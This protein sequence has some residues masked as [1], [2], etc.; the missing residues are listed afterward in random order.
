MTH[1]YFS[2]H[3]LLALVALLLFWFVA[4]SNTSYAQ[5]LDSLKSEVQ[6]EEQLEP[7]LRQKR[8]ARREASRQMLR[9]RRENAS[10][11]ERKLS[12]SESNY[13]MRAGT[14][15]SGIVFGS[16]STADVD[17][18][19]NQDLLITGSDANDNSTTTL[20]LGDGQG[21]FTE[22]SADLTGVQFS[23]SSIA[24]LNGDGNKDLLIAG[25]DESPLSGGSPLTKLYL[26][27]GQGGFT[28]ADADLAD[29]SSGSMSVADVNGDGTQ[30]LL[31]TGND[32]SGEETATMYLGNG[33]GG[34]TEAD[35]GLTGVDHGSTSIADI[36]G[37]GNKDLLIT[38]RDADFDP[39]AT[40]Y[41]GDGEGGFSEANAG[42]TDVG[43][44]S[45][46][47]GDIDK[48]G[49]KDLLIAG[50]DGENTTATLYLGNGQGGFTKA[51]AGLAGAEDGTA[52]IMDVD[53][54]G[55]PDLLITGYDAV[56]FPTPTAT[57]YLGDGQGGFTEGNVGLTG[58]GFSSASIADIGGDGDPDLVIAGSGDSFNEASG[59]LF[60]DESAR[61]YVNRT[62]QTPPNLAPRF[63]Q[64]FAVGSLSPGL[65][66]SRIIEVGDPNGDEIVS[67]QSPNNPNASVSY[68]GDGIAEVTFT[69]DRGQR[70]NAVDIS[71][72]AIDSDGA[73]G[74]FSTSVE[75]TSKVAAF[76]VGFTGTEHGSTSIAD[77][78]GDGNRDPLITGN[79]SSDILPDPTTT[80]Y[81]G[82][83]QGGFTE[84]NAELTGVAYSSTSIADVDRDG[85]KDLLIIGDAA[86]SFGEENLTTTLYLGDG[87]GG[88]TEANAGLTGVDNSSSSIADM[89]GDGNKDL[90]ITGEDANGYPTT[91]LYLGD[92]K[93]DF[94]QAGADLVGVWL[95]SASIADVDEDGNRDLLITG[96][97]GTNNNPDPTT[98]LYL[99]DGQGG[100][101]E[102][103][104]GLTGVALSSTSIADVDGDG[105]KDLL[106]TGDTVADFLDKNP[107]ATLYL[108]DGQGGFTEANAGLTDVNYSSTSIAD[109]DGD[110]NQDLL[111]A[112]SAGTLNNLY[113]K[114]ALYL[115][116]GQGNFTETSVGLAETRY[117]STSIADVDGDADPDFLVTGF[118]STSRSVSSN[119]YENLFGNLDLSA[120]TDL[121]ALSGDGQIELTWSPGNEASPAGYNVYRSTTSFSDISNATKINTSLLGDPS[122]TDSDVTGGTEYFYRVTAVDSDGNE[123]SPSNEASA[124]L[125]P[126]PF[127]DW[128]DLEDPSITLKIVSPE[129]DVSEVDLKM[130]GGSATSS[131]TEPVSSG[132]AEFPDPDPSFSP[133]PRIAKIRLLGPD[134][135]VV[136][137]LPFRYTQSDF[138]S[139]FGI[140]AVIYVHD[141][142]QLQP[143]FG[144]WS[145]EWDYYT[146][147]CPGDNGCPQARPLSMLIPPEGEVENVNSNQQEPVV[148]VH[149]VS[150]RYPAWGNDIGKVRELVGHLSNEG[151]DGWQFYYP[152]NQDITKSG[153]LL[154]KAIHRL[155][156][157]L[158]YGTDQSFD[159]VGH[160]MGGLVSRHYIQRVG[161]GSVRS[162]YSQVL[163]FN[164]GE[165]GS[166]VD[167]FLMLGTPNHGSY[168]AWG[169]T[170]AGKI[171]NILGPSVF[172]RDV[173][174]PAYRQMTPGSGFLN[175][176]NRSPTASNPYS[177]ISTL[178]LAGTRNRAEIPL[179]EIPNQDDVVVAVSSAS[180]LDLGVPLA[181][182]DFTHTGRF[183]DFAVPNLDVLNEDTDTVIT[184]FLSGYDLS[185]PGNL[186]DITGFWG[187]ESGGEADPALSYTDG[188]SANP[189][190]G[191]LTI[192]AEETSVQSLGI[193]TSCDTDGFSEVETCVRI[194]GGK[195]VKT[196][197]SE[198]RFFTHVGSYSQ[199]DGI[200]PEPT[201]LGFG[202]AA[203]LPAKAQRIATVQKYWP[204][205]LEGPLGKISLPTKYLHTTQAHLEFN[206]TQQIAVEASG[207]TPSVGTSSSSENG[208]TASSKSTATEKVQTTK[209]QFQVDTATDTLAFWLARDSTGDVSGHN[210]RL[211]AP[212]GTVID[213]STAKSDPQ[214]GYTQD[215]DVGY[216]IYRVE[217]PAAGRW[218]VRHDASVPMFV[219]APVMSTV[220]LQVNAPDSSFT[221]SETVPVTVSFSGQNTYEDKEITAQLR[222]ENPEGGTTTLGAVGLDESGPTTYEGEFS[223]SYVGSYQISVDFSAQVGGEPVRRRTS[224]TVEVT[225][226]STDTV[227]DPP[228]APTG[229]TAQLDSA[230][231]VSLNWSLEET[232]S[233]EEY[234][235]YRDT[236]PNPTRQVAVV[237]SPDQTSYTDSEIQGGQT[238]YYRVTAVGTG[239]VES[240]FTEGTSVFTYPS[241]LSLDIQRSF[242]NPSSEEGYRLVALPG[243]TDQSLET[244]LGGEAGA[245]WQA[246]WDDGSS[247]DYFQKYDE[248]ET[249]SFRPGRG[250]WV[251]KRSDWT[252]QQS[253]ETVPLGEG[254]RAS[255]SLHEGWNII[256][257]PFG[258]DVA[259]SQVGTANSDSLR[260]LWR[261]DGSFAEADTFRSATSGEAFYFLNDTGL[262][263][264]SIPYPG[265][266]GSEK[267]ESKTKAEKEESPLALTAQPEN[268]K[269]P[270]STVRIGVDEE[271]SS[272]LDRLDQPAPPGQFSPVRLRLEIPG[273][274]PTRQK[275]LMT[276]RRPPP[277]QPDGGHTFQL[278]LQAGTEGPVQVR[279]SDL[280][281][282][283][284][285]EVELL[286][287][288]T[289]Q[290]YDLKAK[291]A[292]TIE[293]VDSTALQ[294]AVGSAAYVQNQVE[295]VV[296]DKVTLTSYPNPMQEQATLEYTLPEAEEVRLTVYDVLGRRVAVLE[297]GRVRAG[298]HQVQ[299][300]GNRLSSGVYFG[301]LQAGGQTRTQKITVVR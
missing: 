141:E 214:F 131:I 271:A 21:S 19:G 270:T 210:M 80:L 252:V 89:N 161:I 56:S 207:F 39:T 100:F 1:P 144:R 232:G 130:G 226:D 175:D 17:G 67:V 136:G 14:S 24:D 283:D 265:G 48:D 111:I 218:T 93:G 126:G 142:P 292:V 2:L 299:L 266:S 133:V 83:G 199:N 301:R 264:L 117:S 6:A 223:P 239:G 244:V 296:P 163:N 92:G 90:L 272:G 158:G 180:L 5:E 297:K 10:G 259:W 35:A 173:G 261:F 263:S 147:D 61:L 30:D 286:R 191:I 287:P 242:G 183:D 66:L 12:K 71:L 225:G 276:E 174:A 155:Q 215:L 160:S 110:G 146:D 195:G 9:A 181:T 282:A 221:T 268:A 269:A 108:G 54:D 178:V 42:L 166:T 190:E 149:G 38:G 197:P 13:V 11:P 156:N 246:Y 129:I 122:Y 193:T 55:N 29:I 253:V 120:P 198:N 237:L 204:G 36:D 75:V 37:D 124:V 50:Y 112:G 105:N 25:L 46:S 32:A 114:T 169:C 216:A 291:K 113:L 281:M 98:T 189:E 157:D 95:S 186:G 104:A 26:A 229:L 121:T 159:L 187:V 209:T 235:I 78:D 16:I 275:L 290:S 171:C 294:L 236:I 27:D 148:L 170:G 182:G 211:T 243:A 288:S 102:A 60:N 152:E 88:F 201:S 58:V 254:E 230:D 212:D 68:Y 298:R 116:D 138:S 285:S 119:L 70:G 31:I 238:Y 132:F 34:F 128:P 33:Q 115:G 279:A 74:S 94:T 107:T 106:I 231:G 153:P 250:F 219:S 20:Y 137:Y 123:S 167:K 23:S 280:G 125:S 47:I 40:L 3:S 293:N 248:S 18:D 295:K 143:L 87:Q 51:D 206:D 103:N 202:A 284:G 217:D 165:P 188:F 22:A 43:D 79:A 245:D 65:T 109:M 247:Q 162:A 150:A 258:R 96:N 233:V 164:P 135:Q 62:N 260:A 274:A 7:L 228:P 224:E 240:S 300:E 49:D 249:F 127:A 118:S 69:P 208:S 64:T 57:L 205:G 196:V 255:I 91:T 251:L 52:S 44:S 200:L 194:G 72:E 86:E 4:V 177:P 289:G 45:T 154:A 53:R 185:A 59:D 203:G 81:L 41:L 101:T 139:G 84:A 256:A 151:Y 99:G 277:T 8:L 273:E 192:N 145:D 97:A 227:P 278:Q 213:S 28:E 257:N 82:D 15:L 172:G 76:P 63:S 222:V 134:G 241:S 267:T 140:D 73:T 176:L 184:N 77:V 234:N 85:N 168:Q 262:D 179:V 220:N